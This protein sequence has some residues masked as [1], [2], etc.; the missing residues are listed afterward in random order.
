MNTD[1]DRYTGRDALIY[2]RGFHDGAVRTKKDLDVK[3]A[4]KLSEI[5]GDEAY[6]ELNR[7]FEMERKTE[8]FEAWS[9]ISH[10][11]KA[12]CE[13]VEAEADVSDRVKVLA[14]DIQG[15]IWNAYLGASDDYEEI[16]EIY[17]KFAEECRKS[18]ERG[19][20]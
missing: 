16:R 5:V 17:E 18:A 13:L 2:D 12:I 4:E 6:F 19:R 20:A 11:A 8:V 1:I 9:K 15:E 10:Y 14:R 3:Y 7:S